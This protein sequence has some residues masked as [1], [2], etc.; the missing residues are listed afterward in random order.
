VE[1]EPEPGAQQEAQVTP[2]DQSG[3]GI[4]IHHRREL[5]GMVPEPLVDLFDGRSDLDAF[6]MIDEGD[7]GDRVSEMVLGFHGFPGK[8]L[9]ARHDVSLTVLRALA[10]A[11]L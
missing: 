7:Q 2:G 1:R 5:V 11:V 10:V 3:V 4:A 6:A 8:A 9:S